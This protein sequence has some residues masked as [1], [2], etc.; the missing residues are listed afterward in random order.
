MER[1]FEAPDLIE[2]MEEAV[3]YNRFLMAQV[4]AW[5]GAGR[6]V[7]DFGAG[8][9]RLATALHDRGLNVFAVEPDPALCERIRSRGIPACPNLDALGTAS[10]DAIYTL[11]VLEHIEDDRAILT[12]LHRRLRPGGRLF[13]YVPAFPALFSANDV[14]VGHRRRYRKQALVA[15]TGETGFRVVRARYVD[16]IGFLAGLL[17]RYFGDANGDLR[18]RAVRLYDRVV[19]PISRVLDHALD[20]IA[21]KNLLIHAVRGA[22]MTPRRGA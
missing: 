5:C 7:L 8:N 12:A 19:F 13:L 3:N 17:Y 2:V 14:R 10:F 16:S 11:N 4:L 1:P 22:G 21:G 20:G 15:L 9:G 18:P 6:S